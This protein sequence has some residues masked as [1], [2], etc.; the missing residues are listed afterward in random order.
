[1]DTWECVGGALAHEYFFSALKSIQQP[2]KP[3]L[4][5]PFVHSTSSQGII[6]VYLVCQC[7]KASV[8]VK[9]QPTIKHHAATHSLSPGGVGGRIRVKVRKLVGLDENSL[10]GKQTLC[11]QAK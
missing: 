3:C 7:Q 1:M 11:A 6:S 4:I 2:R 5:I 10:I 9:P 8:A